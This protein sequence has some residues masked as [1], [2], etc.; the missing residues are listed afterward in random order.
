MGLV[1]I[2]HDI[3]G[4]GGFLSGAVDS[5]LG[6]IAG[7]TVGGSLRGGPGSGQNTGVIQAPNGL[8][9]P[10]SIS[11]DVEGSASVN[12]ARISAQGITAVKIGGSLIGGTANTSGQI[13]TSGFLGP[14]S[15]AGD[16]VGGS[17]SGSGQVTL[18]RSGYIY[19]GNIASISV[20]G[21]AYAGSNTNTNPQS[22]LIHSGW[23]QSSSAIGLLSIGG[24]LVGNATNPII[25]SA[26]GLGKGTL[27]ADTAI[28]A[29]KVNGSVKFTDILAGYD[30]FNTPKDG[31]ASIGAVRIG[32]DWIASS[33]VAGVQTANG[34]MNFGTTTDTE[35]GGTDDGG[36]D[37]I[38]TIASI[39]IGGQAQGS[40][41]GNGAHYGFVAEE[42]NSFSVGGS[43][44]P[45]H[46]GP[47]NEGP[48]VAVGS[49]GNLT[50]FEIP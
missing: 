31:Q 40:A 44:Y 23:I 46:P 1:H 42:I 14:V 35:I 38:A 33:I 27:T 7:V 6:D 3:V 48:P 32:L 17:I 13:D 24:S 37:L 9:G 11:S 30:P 39:V 22:A 41:N 16:L 20:G 18:D 49:T 43:S 15:I 21:S 34:S 26:Q 10:V 45:L 2:G 29:V 4:G 5:R 36:E 47:S 25:V 8:L 12:S 19:G 28:G 50:L